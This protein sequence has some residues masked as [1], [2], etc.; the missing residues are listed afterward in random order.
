M[1]DSNEQI[2]F[3][4]GQRRSDAEW[5]SV[6][7]ICGAHTWF[8]VILVFSIITNAIISVSIIIINGR[9]ISIVLYAKSL[10]V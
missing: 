4:A 3:P 9:S 6:F 1:K 5:I 8:T 2:R 7:A 10:L